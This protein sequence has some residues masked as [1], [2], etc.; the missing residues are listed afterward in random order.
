MKNFSGRVAV[1]TGAASGFGK[2]FALL[3]ASL[4]MKLVLADVQ[5]EALDATANEEHLATGDD[6]RTHADDR[7]I[8]ILTRTHSPITLTTTRLRR[9]PSNSA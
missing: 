2:E 9:C 7:P 1:I 4:G 3:G 8:G 6:H 5:K